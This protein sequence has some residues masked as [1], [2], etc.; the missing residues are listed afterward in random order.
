MKCLK[1]PRR[2]PRVQNAAEC[3]ER[4]CNVNSMLVANLLNALHAL[5]KNDFG[6]TGMKRYIDAFLANVKWLQADDDS[7]VREYRLSSILREIPYISKARAKEILHKLALQ[8][9][10][11]DRIVLEAQAFEAGLIE[12][13]ILMVS[14]LYDDFG[15][16]EKRIRDVITRWEQG[17]IGDGNAWLLE[18]LDF[19]SD[20]ESEKR[21]I[22]DILLSCKRKPPRT[23]LREQMEARR[24]LEALKA[25]QD[26]VRGYKA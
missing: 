7:E 5:Y 14:T 12:N 22:V 16:R 9:T 21:E 17:T 20:P 19:Q 26:D 24:E 3:Y 8:S 1:N 2:D 11:K 15:F 25:Y 4:A 6:R 18:K 23:T 10:A 13:I